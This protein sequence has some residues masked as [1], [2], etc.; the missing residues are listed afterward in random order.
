MAPGQRFVAQRMEAN[1]HV[2]SAKMTSQPGDLELCFHGSLGKYCHI[3]RRVPEGNSLFD[4]AD[5]YSG[6][7]ITDNNQNPAGQW[8]ESA[9]DEDVAYHRGWYK[10]YDLDGRRMEDDEHQGDTD[11]SEAEGE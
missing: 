8:W 5:G 10:R 3:M 1:D 9:N 6:N 4:P 2:G 7:A 11:E